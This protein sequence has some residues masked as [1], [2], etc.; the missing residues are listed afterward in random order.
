MNK[1]SLH[2]AVALCACVALLAGC[3]DL[4]AFLFGGEELSSYEFDSYAG[5]RECESYIALAGPVD[6]DRVHILT[7]A[8]G[9][10]TVYAVLLHDDTVCSSLDTLILYFHGKGPHIDYYWPRT[11]MLYELDTGYVSA[12]G[13]HPYP[14]LAID[15]QG[16]GMSSG[17]PTEDNLN[18]DGANALRFVQDHLG[19][20]SVFVYGFSL[21]TLVA[22]KV[23]AED[24]T[25]RVIGLAMEAPVGS[26]SQI[27]TD[28]T[29]L[30]VPGS[31]VSTFTG[32]NTEE[33]GGVHVPYLW[34]H[35]TNDGTLAIE[36]CGWPVW[37]NYVGPDGARRI[38]TGGEHRD[39]PETMSKDFVVYK[40]TV[41]WFVQGVHGLHPACYDE[42][43]P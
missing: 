40:Q 5:E 41:K 29:F 6:M 27:V 7:I 4:D 28:A 9:G 1:R 35:G 32:D 34:L 19:D 36:T 21:G 8:S 31:A 20:P 17:E 14:V 12:G 26:I 16:Y 30:N 24:V 43:V 18:E 10:Q 25:G 39:V 42:F 33:I 11:R 38:V 3:L 23:A 2:A 37:D 13:T 22:C 15:Y